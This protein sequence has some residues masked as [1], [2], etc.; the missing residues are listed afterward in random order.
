MS[1]QLPDPCNTNESSIHKVV[2]WS[3]FVSGC[4]T[5]AVGIFTL[6]QLKSALVCYLGISFIVGG[7]LIALM[8]IDTSWSASIKKEIPLFGR[9][10]GVALLCVH[11]AIQVLVTSEIV[12]RGLI[13][14]INGIYLI[15]NGVILGF[16]SQ[17]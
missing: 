2:R 9:P 13:L 15:F 7:G 5:A 3:C 4:T 14:F 10:R 11:M 1:N 12:T 8:N 17:K 16:Y 6:T